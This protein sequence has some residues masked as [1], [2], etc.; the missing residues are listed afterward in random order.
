M[1]IRDRYY[2]QEKVDELLALGNLL[3]LGARLSPCTKLCSNQDSEADI[4]LAYTRDYGDS[5][6]K[7]KAREFSLNEL[8]GYNLYGYKDVSYIYVFAKPDKWIYCGP[9][10]L[11]EEF[12]DVKKA[13][14]FMETKE[15]LQ[16]WD[17]DFSEES[18]TMKL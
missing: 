3:Y 9:G 6:E 16:D 13:L 8:Y 5:E 12:R 15:T 1:C 11:D 4:T 10:E 2:T 17:E 7:T 14:E 18:P